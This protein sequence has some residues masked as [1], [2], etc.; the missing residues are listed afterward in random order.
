MCHVMRILPVLSSNPIEIIFLGKNST[1]DKSL[2]PFVLPFE[3]TNR[4][5]NQCASLKRFYAMYHRL[6][7]DLPGQ[8]LQQSVGCKRTAVDSGQS[9]TGHSG[10][11]Q[12]TGLGP[13]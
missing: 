7:E 3:F 6:F 2:T 11:V 5:L 8:T 10:R 12:L 1:P 13:S 4:L 9:N